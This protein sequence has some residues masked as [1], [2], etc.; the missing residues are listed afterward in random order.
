MP[1]I[2]LESQ[3]KK[4]QVRE[5]NM[6]NTET[7]QSILDNNGLFITE[8]AN[9]EPD[10]EV[11]DELLQ[12]ASE[13]EDTDIQSPTPPN[14]PA[15]RLTKKSE[16]KSSRKRP[17]VKENRVSNSKERPAPPPP[18]QRGCFGEWSMASL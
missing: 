11:E 13:D 16:Q 8:P 9:E 6:S 3:R 1:T 15:N 7:F 5:R 2:K 12:S 18:L 17:F 4:H 14:E 10:H